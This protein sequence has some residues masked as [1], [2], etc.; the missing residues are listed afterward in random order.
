VVNL[1]RLSE[2]LYGDVSNW[3]EL[4]DANNVVPF[5]TELLPDTVP[6]DTNRV[7]ELIQKLPT[8]DEVESLVRDAIRDA[9]G[10]IEE[11]LSDVID[12]INWLF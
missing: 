8:R 9:T 4:M 6:L 1:N 5:L 3:R 7:D 11:K 2:E 12:Q 10:K